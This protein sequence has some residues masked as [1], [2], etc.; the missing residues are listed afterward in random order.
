MRFPRALAALPLCVLLL[1]S[2]AHAQD[3]APPEPAP[4]PAPAPAPEPT[5]EPA[6]AESPIDKRISLEI[7]GYHDS[8]A[9]S[10]LTPSL[11]ANVTNPTAGW[12]VNGRY[13]VDVVTAASPDIV[14]TASP[15]WTETRHA[16]SFGAQYKPGNIG[17]GVNA[18]VSYTD[19]YLALSGGGQLIAD[20]DEKN[21]TLIGGYNF[22]RDTVGRTGTAFSIFGR[23]VAFHTGTLGVTR[24]LSAS[25]LVTFVVDGI[26]ERGDQSKP[27]RYVPMFAPGVADQIPAG[28][29]AEEI[30]RQR[31][32]ARPLEQLPLER[33]RLALTSRFAHRGRGWTV[34]A[35]E[36]LYADSWGLL[37]SSTDLRVP[38]DVSQRVV[39]W[40][41]MRLHV[42]NGVSF[43][44]RAYTATSAA[45][46][47]AARTG[48]RELGPLTTTGV[49]AGARWGLGSNRDPF[50][51]A[52]LTTFDGYWTHFSD[53]IYVK[54]RL[55]A[56]L[57]LTLEVAF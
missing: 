51:V 35:E 23:P 7:A 13:L 11:A 41:H 48:D 17:G 44:R 57:S 53:A 24:L 37:A 30:A 42:Q 22:G 36:R 16:G 12:N 49:G 20:L 33:E 39:L 3:P 32:Q 38:F 15:R 54:D 6:P 56:L 19:D 43:W 4:A 28:A 34:R 52:L 26:L 2:L 14:A 10:V 40:P 21:W 45:D 25:S 5:P 1:T 50:G 8:V 31:V 46:L 29:S 55:S 9:V 18:N 47:P 27:Y